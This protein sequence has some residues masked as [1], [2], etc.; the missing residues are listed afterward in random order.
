MEIKQYQSNSN[1]E[2]AQQKK[3]DKEKLNVDKI[4]SISQL[5]YQYKLSHPELYFFKDKPDKKKKV[6]KKTL[7]QGDFN[8]KSVRLLNIDPMHVNQ[9]ISNLDG[10]PFKAKIDFTHKYKGKII[11]TNRQDKEQEKQAVLLRK[12]TKVRMSVQDKPLK[13]FNNLNKMDM[14]RDEANSSMLTNY[15][16]DIRSPIEEVNDEGNYNSNHSARSLIKIDVKDDDFKLPKI[17][18]EVRRSIQFTQYFSPSQKQQ[19]MDSLQES[20]IKSQKATQKKFLLNQP[21]ANNNH[22]LGKIGNGVKFKVRSLI[23]NCLKLEQNSS[24]EKIEIHNIKDKTLQ[25][26]EN[27]QDFATYKQE[28]WYDERSLDEQ[29]NNHIELSEDPNFIKFKSSNLITRQCIANMSQ[30]DKTFEN[31]R[32]QEKCQVN[33]KSIQEFNE[34]CVKDF[35][36]HQR[37]I[38]S[39]VNMGGHGGLNILPQKRWNVYRQDNRQKVEDDEKLLH[40]AREEHYRNQSI[41]NLNEQV[42][43]LKTQNT[44]NDGRVSNQGNEE[45]KVAHSQKQKEELT[46]NEIY[47]RA[48]KQ[49]RAKEKG[50]KKMIESELMGK[51]DDSQHV[52]LFKQEQI[53]IMLR[54]KQIEKSGEVQGKEDYL[55][56]SGNLGDLFKDRHRPWYVKQQ[57]QTDDQSN[58][59]DIAANQPKYDKSFEQFMIKEQIKQFKSNQGDYCQVLELDINKKFDGANAQIQDKDQECDSISSSSSSQKKSKKKDKKK[60]DKK[61]DKKEKKK[62]KKEKKRQ[63]KLKLEQLREE[64]LKREEIERKRVEQLLRQNN[65]L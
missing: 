32:R 37:Q 47:Q 5:I 52:N 54:Q 34:E 41:S 49:L 6:N 59:A 7:Q 28:C 4:R 40:Q 31:H 10:R 9:Q 51:I 24:R 38:I 26:Y 2:I 36:E 11:L 50:D 65:K 53:D 58:A 25:D 33:F 43:V 56:R 55:K 45:Q 57:I 8:S 46:D 3:Y 35:K 44:N 39:K 61:R 20:P 42:K 21:S 13:D 27:I 1:Q 62:L 14:L 18:P 64:R 48:R 16:D 23:K 29:Q 22:R 63:D 12:L 15:F 17:N 19:E 60:T 30:I